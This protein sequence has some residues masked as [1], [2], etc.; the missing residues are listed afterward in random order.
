[1]FLH[2]L[3]KLFNLEHSDQPYAC[4]DLVCV[5]VRARVCV[6]VCYHVCVCVCACARVPL[7]V[8][9]TVYGLWLI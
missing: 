1:M 6:C 8:Y 5:Y 7:Q 2:H 3:S 4:F 9:V